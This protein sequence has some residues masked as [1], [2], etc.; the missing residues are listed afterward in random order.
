MKPNKRKQRSRKKQQSK[1]VEQ[2]AQERTHE[3]E[4]LQQEIIIN[5]EKD[6]DHEIT[7]AQGTDIIEHRHWC[8]LPIDL[9][10]LIALRLSRT[11][12]AHLTSVC[13]SWRSIGPLSFFLRHPLTL[14]S[15]DMPLMKNHLPWLMFSQKEDDMYTFWDPLY[16]KSYTANIPQLS[17]SRLCFCKDGWVFVQRGNDSVF[18]F[19]PFISEEIRLPDYHVHL[20][21][22]SI[23][24]SAT[25]T[26]SDSVICIFASDDE[27]EMFVRI[28]RHGDM[29]WTRY[30]CENNLPFL[31]SYANPVFLDEV[32]YVLGHDGK[33]AVFDPKLSIWEVCVKPKPLKLCKCSTYPTCK[34]ENCL[35]ESRGKLLMVF[36]G[37]HGTQ[38]HV[39]RLS[40]DD[41]WVKIESLEDRWTSIS[42]TAMAER[43]ANKIYF[44]IRSSCTTDGV[45][46][47]LK[48]QRSY[49]NPN[50]YGTDEHINCTWV[51]PRWFRPSAAAL[52]WRS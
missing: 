15:P 38:I 4:K 27:H 17:G 51:E 9:V 26:S 7:I 35:L 12:F 34:W 47:S 40:P 28:C 11:D 29:D 48:D 8:D 44:P 13:R 23:G 42:C 25:P 46:F 6:I 19:N 14:T 50:F 43:M 21:L 39:Y 16:N 30:V 41:E 31:A 18:L 1:V 5:C 2:V 3:S 45:F 36:V 37:F 24:I 32:F 22:H 33:I 49:P 20:G 52:A 10:E